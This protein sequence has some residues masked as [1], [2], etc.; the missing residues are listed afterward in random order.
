MHAHAPGVN[1]LPGGYPVTVTR[2]GGQL[3]LPAGLSLDEAI[4]VNEHCQRADGI[5]AIEEN[6]TVRFTGREMAIMKSMLGYECTRM[7]L[8][9]VADQARE[10]AAKF[11][12][13][14]LKINLSN[15][16]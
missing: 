2:S 6:G 7:A 11:A 14:K 5:E 1:G 16:A 8:T 9:D 15:A 4:A 13:F 12:E 10:L 3:D